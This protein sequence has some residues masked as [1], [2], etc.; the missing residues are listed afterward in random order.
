MSRGRFRLLHLRRFRSHP[1]RT[2]LAVSSIAVGTALVT[3]ILAVLGSI[4]GSVDELVDLAGRADVEVSGVGDTGF[5]DDLFFAVEDTAGVEAAVPVIR[6]RVSVGGHET[7]LFGFDQ[8]AE[9]L[10]QDLAEEARRR[11]DAGDDLDGVFLSPGLADRIGLAPGDPVSVYGSG[12]RSETE[13]L[14]VVDVPGFEVN[15]GEFAVAALPLA[16]R[17]AGKTGRL[18]AVWAVAEDGS[19]PGALEARLDRELGDR[20]VVSSP[21]L[22]AEQAADEVDPFEQQLLVIAG[23]VLVV[24][25]FVVFNTMSMAALERRRELATL[26]ALGGHRNRLLAG[27]LGESAILGAVGSLA[28]VAVGFLAARELVE[29]LPTA[30]TSGVEVAIGFH[31]PAGTLPIAAATGIGAAVLAAAVPARRAVNVPP[32]DAMRPGDALETPAGHPTTNWFAGVVGVGAL[33]AGTALTAGLVP[34]LVAAGGA[35]MVLAALLTTWGFTPVITRAAAWIAGRA[36]TS[37]RLA[38]ATIARAPRRTWATSAGVM[39]AAGLVVTIGGLTENERRTM[40]AHFAPLGDMDVVVQSAPLEDFPTSVMPASWQDE[41]EALPGVDEVFPGQFAFTTFDERRTILQGY[42]SGRNEPLARLADDDARSRLLAGEGAVVNTMFANAHDV[43]PGDTVEIPTPSGPRAVRVLDEVAFVG[44][45]VGGGLAGVSVDLMEDWFDREGASWYELELAPGAERAEVARRV[46]ELTSGAP[47]P[48][49]VATGE[50]LFDAA[51]G[52]V[53]Q[54]DR[55]F[56]ALA[57]IAVVAGGLGI[58]NTLMLSVLERRREL[59]ILRAMGTSRRQVRNMV[60]AEA[61]AI[62]AVGTA[63]GASTGALMHWAAVEGADELIGLHVDYAFTPVP[64][65]TAA[66][67][68]L[69]MSALGGV[70]PGRRASK[71]NVIAAIGYE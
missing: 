71:V 65:A 17:F 12:R 24:A 18:D 45:G 62:A 6:S 60:L 8:R 20:A 49:F 38:A 34:E 29:A 70:G 59:G 61:T 19:S 23:A 50:E 10:G 46:E 30:I 66:V 35:V 43:E 25:A 47:F 7:F 58:L 2:A 55:I 3:A 41:L 9:A 51:I 48:V 37:G 11:I 52:V 69:L 15:R 56:S 39:V 16:Q 13:V 44:G 1:G 68:A 67:V 5:E 40:A 22:R 57:W 31:P 32:V 21:R 4:T 54:F 14:D 26:R 33:A 28:G 27:F 42:S 36:R 64:L 53:E 63:L